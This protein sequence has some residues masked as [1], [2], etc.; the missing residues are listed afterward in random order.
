MILN[1][2]IVQCY[3]V[4]CMCDIYLE[5]IKGQDYIIETGDYPVNMMD[6]EEETD[7]DTQYDINNPGIENDVI[8]KGVF[9]FFRHGEYKNE[10]RSN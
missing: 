8:H 5:N 7:E 3:I 10:R 9:K 4:H 6:D 1:F 2:L